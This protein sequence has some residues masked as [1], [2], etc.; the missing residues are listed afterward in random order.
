MALI[1]QKGLLLTSAGIFLVLMWML[2]VHEVQRSVL[3][4]SISCL[5]HIAVV[6]IVLFVSNICLLDI[7]EC[8]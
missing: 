3:S 6:F 1:H 4:V 2:A 8:R 7:D 5:C